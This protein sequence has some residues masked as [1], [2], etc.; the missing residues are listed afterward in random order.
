MNH[1]VFFLFVF[2]L[3]LSILAKASCPAGHVGQTLTMQLNEMRNESSA[4]RRRHVT[5][6]QEKLWMQ[7][8]LLCKNMHKC[9]HV[10]GRAGWEGRTYVTWTCINISRTVCN[11]AQGFKSG[12]YQSKRGFASNLPH[13]RVFILFSA[14]I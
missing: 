5:S 1:C 2:F 6:G 14:I 13:Q 4:F 3:L 10:I 12:V 7:H 11:V 9:W 8:I